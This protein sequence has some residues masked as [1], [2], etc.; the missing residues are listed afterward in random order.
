M[1]SGIMILLRS[2]GMFILSFVLIKIIGKRPPTRTKPFNF[3]SYLVIA[4]I[5]AAV[6]LNIMKN[7]VFGLIAIGVWTIFPIALDYLAMKSQLIN[8]WL[9]GKAT[10]LIKNG[11]IMEKNIKQVRYTSEDLLRELR[12]KNAFSLADVEFAVMETTGDLN[13]LLKS[14]KKPATPKDIKIK[15]SPQPE[16]QTVILDGNIIDESLSNLGFNRGWLNAQLENA[17]VDLA[18][19]FIGQANGVGELYLD[20]FDDKLQVQKPKVREMLMANL[21]KCKAELESFALE[22]LDAHAKKMYVKN[23]GEIDKLIKKLE[24]YLLR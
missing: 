14:D 16:P 4:F 9:N 8:E 13:V 24:P 19:V 10:V 5:A 15:V 20:L 2:I 6:S 22:T 21:K 12:S 3:V 17:G 1:Q 7:I 11:K 18:N 23:I